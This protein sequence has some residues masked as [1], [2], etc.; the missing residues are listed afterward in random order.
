M[1]NQKVYQ[2]IQAA[3]AMQAVLNDDCQHP[4]NT[5][6]SQF[7]KTTGGRQECLVCRKVRYQKR[8][9]G[10]WGAWRSRDAK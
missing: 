10:P 2:L 1:Q 4:H 9:Q 8:H 7:P 3:Q 6:L 5:I